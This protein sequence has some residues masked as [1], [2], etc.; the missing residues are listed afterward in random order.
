MIRT[1]LLVTLLLI[2]AVALAQTSS[3]QTGS[4]NASIT[5]DNKT[6]QQIQNMEQQGKNALVKGDTNWAQ[7]NLADDFVGVGSKTG[8]ADKQTAISNRQ[9]GKLKYDSIEPRNMKIRVL[10]DTA[11][12][13]YEATAKGSYEGHDIGGDYAVTHV[14]AKRGGKWQLLNSQSTKMEQ[15][16]SAGK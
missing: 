8:M 12:V 5:G 7:Q 16:E 14:W 11:L 9:T 3:S 4:M 6:G 1:T 13:N 2:A 10:G 15:T